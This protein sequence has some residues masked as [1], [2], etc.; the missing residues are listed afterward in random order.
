SGIPALREVAGDGAYFFDPYEPENIAEGIMRV[1]T[2]EHLRED[3]KIR[4]LERA[5]QFSWERCARETW[6]VLEG[7][8]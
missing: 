8:R 4:G 7:L 3:L 2:D 5:K 1:L 6:K